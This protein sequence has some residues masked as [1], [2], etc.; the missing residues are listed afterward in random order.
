MSSTPR[1]EPRSS[2]DATTLASTVTKK[3]AQ[4]AG[5]SMRVVSLSMV[6]TFLDVS[7]NTVLSWVRQGCPVER[8]PVGKGDSYELDL[9]DVINWRM[10]QA[11]DAAVEKA[12]AAAKIPLPPGGSFDGLETKDEADTRR[13]RALANM[14]EM[15]EAIKAGSVVAVY[16]V[17]NMV[18]GDYAK[19]R[20]GLSNIGAELAD[21]TSGITDPAQVKA[22]ADKLVRDAIDHLVYRDPVTAGM[23]DEDDEGDDEA[24][25]AA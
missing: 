15:D 16:A 20:T 18:R 7:R 22:V 19:L 4:P 17:E 21:K 23:D 6:A 9:A 2:L 12:S 3:K 1:R 24:R 25:D 13:A 11:V 10:A 14:A 5:K 8:E